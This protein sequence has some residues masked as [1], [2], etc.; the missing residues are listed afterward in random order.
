MEYENIQFRKKGLVA[1]ITLNRPES[2]NA[3]NVTLC[4]ELLDAMNKCGWDKEIRAVVLTGT[5]KAFC[6]GG[7]VR[8]I[9]GFL[10]NY[11]HDDPGKI[12][13]EIVSVFHPLILA[14]RKLKKPVIGAINGFCSGGG[15]GVAQACDILIAAESAKIHMAYS[16]IA[17]VPDGGNSFF[18]TQTVGLHKASELIFTGDII[19]AHEAYRLGIFNQIVP[20]ANL[21]SEAEKLAK[22]LAHG[23]VFAIG[24]TKSLLNKAVSGSL[25][26]QLELEKEAVITC[27]GTREFKEG[28]TAFFEKRK[29]DF[30][31]L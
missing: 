8:D 30:I 16:A 19:D 20:D 26:T 10:K 7:D 11:P 25:E 4:N 3:L 21:M 18:L 28:I 2:L 13:E 15:A 17:E 14:I 6:A 29:P 9:R 5:G 27:A 31:K 24:L 22:R 23:P 12:I 1:T